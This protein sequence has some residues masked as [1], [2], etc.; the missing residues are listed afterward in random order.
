MFV[1]SSCT[2]AATSNSPTA[3][4]SPGNN[5]RPAL[6][7]PSVPATPSPNEN[8]PSVPAT[9]KRAHVVRVVDGDTVVIDGI[10]VGY[11]Q[12]RGFGHH[13]RLIGIDTPEIH[14]RVGCF[15]PQAAAFTR[16]E[17]DGRDVLVD[18]DVSPT[19]RFGRAL[20]YIWKTDGTFFNGELATE[21]YALQLTIPPDVRYADLFTRYVRHARDARRGLWVSCE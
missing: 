15:G 19:D 20:V 18:F 7:P 2:S 11:T 4:V 17:V 8:W 1:V 12:R 21:G 13:A 16:R 5:A 9:A 3:T 14:G 6:G 10:D